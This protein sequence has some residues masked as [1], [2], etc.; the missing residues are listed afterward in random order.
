MATFPPQKKQVVNQGGDVPDG[1]FD[2]QMGDGGFGIYNACVSDGTSV[3]QF[4][5][6][7]SQWGNQY[8]G[9]YNR[10]GLF[11]V[12]FILVLVLSL[13]L[14][15]QTVTTFLPTLTATPPTL[16]TCKICALGHLTRVSGNLLSDSLLFSLLSLPC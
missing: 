4:D 1:N 2:L 8:G 14:L 15:F 6:S 13:N 16:T 5:G 11:F 9:W 12:Y 3:P 7:A 10:N